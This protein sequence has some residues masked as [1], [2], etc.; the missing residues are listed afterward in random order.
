MAM[1]RAGPRGGTTGAEQLLFTPGPRLGWVFRDRRELAAPFPEPQ[2]SP[3]AIGAQ[4]ADAEQAWRRAWKWIGMPS[5]LVAAMVLALEGCAQVVNGSFSPG[6]LLTAIVLCTPGLVYA[7]WQWWRREQW[8]G[9]DPGQEYR[10]ALAGWSQRAAG[11]E[12]AELARL[13]GQPEWGS[14]T[15]PAGRTDVYGGSA[16]GGPA[17]LAAPRPPPPA[18]RPPPGPAP[19]PPPR[20][21]Q[22]S[23]PGPPA[24]PPAPPGAPRPAG[25][26]PRRPP[27]GCPD[28]S[29][30]PGQARPPSSSPEPKSSPAPTPNDSPGPA[31]SARSPS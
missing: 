20:P 12:D 11:H 22:R 3:Q 13:S 24:G 7:G 29:P 10:Q 15:V 9:I 5:A 2:P 23:P 21:G 25:P 8:R 4:A 28:G 19:A 17:R 31:S 6:T 1:H 18:P 26:P 27:R 30:P 16:A 14:L